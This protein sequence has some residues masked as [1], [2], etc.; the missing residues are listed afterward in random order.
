MTEWDDRRNPGVGKVRERLQ[1]RA[2]QM[3]GQSSVFLLT[4]LV[5]KVVIFLFTIFLART[6]GADRLGLFALGFS[7][8]TL[9]ATVALY[10]LPEASL[11]FLPHYDLAEEA[12]E[13]RNFVVRAVRIVAVAA[14]I[15]GVA[16]VLLREPL[17]RDVFGEP[18]LA[19]YLPAFAAAVVLLSLYR[20]SR[21]VLRGLQEA[22]REALRNLTAQVGTRV[23][24]TVVLILA[25][26]GL[27]GYVAGYLAGLM[28]ALVVMGAAIWWKVGAGP[29]WR[30][31][32]PF[33]SEVHDF[34]RLSLG[35]SLVAVA[36]ERGDRLLLGLYLPAD[37]IGVYD[38]AM[39]AALA[40]PVVLNAANVVLG[41]VISELHERQEMVLLDVLAERTNKWVTALTVPI[42][43][44]I[45][46]YAPEVMGLFGERFAAG[47][48][49][50]VIL[51]G[52][53]VVNVSMGSTGALASMSGH[54][55][56]HF[57]S[58]LI[59]AGTLVSLDLALIPLWGSAGAAWAFLV[60]IV[61]QHLY[62][63][64]VV[65]DRVGVNPLGP[66]FR[67]VL[68]PAAAAAASVMGVRFATAAW[69]DPWW[70][71]MG[72]A[73][74]VGYAVVLV[75]LLGKRKDRVDEVMLD[76]VRGAVRR[77]LNGGA[78]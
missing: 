11:R 31:E 16:L 57:Q 25:G 30:G 77:A 78:E 26:L 56:Q 73:A 4:L 23:G 71:S 68:L 5:S 63:W 27:W 33:E 19:P 65:T 15:A 29:G 14:G 49:V 67:A 10:G 72:V 58:T 52:A 66:G 44:C 18:E 36:I 32:R 76:G 13:V 74:L 28:V 59:A 51:V 21:H 69:L 42:A 38:V 2:A 20:L 43:A 48:R 75:G 7:M 53:Q 35:G 41:P 64:R 12:S 1:E 22:A 8:T 46:A 39:S 9:L 24:L 40:L 34:S 47:W 45:C 50:L 60:A 61:L 62:L 37:E 17:A 3:A 54:Q 6:L 70:L 55:R